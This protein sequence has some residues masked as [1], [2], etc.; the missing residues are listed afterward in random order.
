MKIITDNLGF[1]LLE[2]CPPI[3]EFERGISAHTFLQDNWWGN[4]A[5]DVVHKGYIVAHSIDG[6]I[7]LKVQV[8]W[9]HK[10]V[11]CPHNGKGIEYPIKGEQLLST[12]TITYRE[13]DTTNSS[14]G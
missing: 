14:N 13:Y 8:V 4:R 9:E 3:S 6:D 12:T 11:E 7:K 5:V 10:E 1:I 2:D